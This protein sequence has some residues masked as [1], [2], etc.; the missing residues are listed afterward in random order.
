MESRSNIP[1][2]E[3]IPIEVDRVIPGSLS[4]PVTRST[5]ENNNYSVT[6]MG[7][8][9][10]ATTQTAKGKSVRMD[11]NSREPPLRNRFDNKENQRRYEEIK[12]WAFIIE[13]KVQLQP[14]HYDIFLNG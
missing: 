6:K 12:Y 13:R 1:G 11:S 2:K 14:K 4:Q 3:Q 9:K 5:D 8:T 10:S 7:Q